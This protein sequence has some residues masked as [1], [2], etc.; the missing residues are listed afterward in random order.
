MKAHPRPLAPRA[1]RGPAEPTADVVPRHAAR[2][3][4]SAVGPAPARVG[5]NPA[6]PRPASTPRA[7]RP[8]DG[9]A[10]LPRALAAAACVSPRPPRPAIPRPA[11][12]RPAIP[13]PAIPRPARSPSARRSAAGR[14]SLVLAAAAALAAAPAA[15]QERPVLTVYAYDSFTSEFGP[16]AAIE[17]AFEPQCGCD[18]RFVA[19]GDGAALLARLRLEG[20]RTRADV[21]MGFD[22]DLM[23]RAEGLMMPH[24]VE[25]EFDLPIEWDDP[26][27]LPF[28]WS[29]LAFVYREGAEPGEGLD[30][31]TSF[32]DLAE[33]DVQ[34]VIEDPRSSTPGLA[35][36]LWVDEAYG[37]EAAAIWEAMA[38]NVV[39]VTKGWS[40]A[41]GLFL[42]GEADMALSYT[43][44]PAY[45]LIAEGDP[46]VKAAPFEE[47][48]YLQIEL[49]SIVATTDQPELAREFMA[50]VV[51][52]AFQGLI[53]TGN[54]SYPSVTPEG[55]LPEGFETLIRPERSLLVPPE[56]A[57]A[58]AEEAIATWRDALSR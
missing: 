38:D 14:A 1:C 53:A 32:R 37:D 31:P 51:S 13:R 17:A 48:H 15:A 45:H 20:E 12:P 10:S 26:V 9:R 41:Y 52:D 5:T 2:G 40:E 8:A 24:G 35:M 30:P 49:A 16:G 18:L 19:A 58:R 42:E 28:D 43:T 33:S 22:T 44:S 50:F 29:W 36:V 6:V 7:G 39:T 47:G 3:D 57:E 34:V 56:E 46:S 4:G 21:V 54:W 55:G 27:F 25:A 23:A 11:I